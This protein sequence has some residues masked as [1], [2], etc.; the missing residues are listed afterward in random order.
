LVLAANPKD[1][2]QCQGESGRVFF[3]Q[4]ELDQ[5]RALSNELAV[6]TRIALAAGDPDR[7]RAMVQE[8]LPIP[9]NP[10]VFLSSAF[11]TGAFE[12]AMVQARIALEEGRASDA[13]REAEQAVK[14]ARED[15][16]PDDEAA[17]EAVFALAWLAE[18][19]LRE[20]QQAIARL[21]KRLTVTQDRLLRL[22]GGIS[23][24]RVQAASKRP[25]QVK[26]ARQRLE[27]L[28]REAADIGAVAIAFEAR[29]ALGEIEIT[30]GD[31]PAGRA[32]LEGLA[33]DATAKGFVNTARKAAV[34]ARVDPPRAPAR[35]TFAQLDSGRR[36]QDERPGLVGPGHRGPHESLSFTHPCGS[37]FMRFRL[38]RSLA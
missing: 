12:V 35:L 2:S 8:A 23:V 3:E 19:R 16:R 25:D 11:L 21:E 13:R 9:T 32:R 27:T 22:S 14:L 4:G 26:V 6:L 7:A 15:F 20:A 38:Q 36:T 28:I 10:R 5:A 30:A 17:A 37:H 31:V 18:G 33:R 1:R 34:A 29:L 24:A